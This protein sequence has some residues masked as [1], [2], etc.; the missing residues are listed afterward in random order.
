M[1]L[2]LDQGE[3]TVIVAAIGVVG[4]VVGGLLNRKNEQRAKVYRASAD[5]AANAAAAAAH[6]AST[7]DAKLSVIDAQLRANGGSSTFDLLMKRLRE[8]DAAA[9]ARH[10][11]VIDRFRGV[12]D[13]ISGVDTRISGIDARV[14]NIE[15]KS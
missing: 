10:Q 9:A 6:A 2:A 3:A 11:D 4:T 8:Q 7:A 15:K 14:A 13:R 5:E 1:V 12:N